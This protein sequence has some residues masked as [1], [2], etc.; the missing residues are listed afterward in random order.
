MG[1]HVLDEMDKQILMHIQEDARF[2]A[3]EIAK[4]VGVSDNTIH[5]RINRLEEAGVIT[6]YRTALDPEQTGLGLHVLLTCTAPL[7]DRQRLAEKAIAVPEVVEVTELMTGERNLLI[8]AVSAEDDDIKRVAHKL[9]GLGIEVHDQ[10]L[11]SANHDSSLDFFE[12]DTM[13]DD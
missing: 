8:K 3:T 5:H 10:T 2:A 9:D 4:E 1:F 13:L 11:I 6:G 7:A 12:L